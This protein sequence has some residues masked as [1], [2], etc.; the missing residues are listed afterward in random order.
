M[1]SE[2]LRSIFFM[3]FPSSARPEVHRASPPPAAPS[4][5]ERN[6]QKIERGRGNLRICREDHEGEKKGGNGQERKTS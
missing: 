3:T 4:S 2:Y 1:P 5:T 6:K